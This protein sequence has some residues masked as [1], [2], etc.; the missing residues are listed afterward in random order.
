MQFGIIRQA[1]RQ[2]ACRP[3]IY[4]YIIRCC[5]SRTLIPRSKYVCI[6]WT[7]SPCQKP[8]RNNVRFNVA[9]TEQAVTQLLN[10]TVVAA[11]WWIGIYICDRIRGCRP[12]TWWKVFPRF[13][14]PLKLIHR[15]E[16]RFNVTGC[17]CIAVCCSQS[18]KI[19][20]LVN[21][22][23]VMVVEVAEVNPFPMATV[24]V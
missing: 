23:T 7:V 14:G 15:M 12:N 18:C 16:I 13:L 8:S 1:V 17:I 10:N 11:S 9:D 24:T 22:F 6:H 19:Y 5:W 2:A 4:L 3:E 21:G 20:N